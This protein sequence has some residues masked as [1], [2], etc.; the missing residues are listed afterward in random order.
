M[1]I[2]YHSRSGSR[3]LPC[4]A[5]SYVVN[6]D[7]YSGRFSLEVDGQRAEE[8]TRELADR[9]LNVLYDPSNPDS[10][11]IPVK[12]FAGFPLHQRLEEN[13]TKLYPDD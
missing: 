3:T 1:E 5:F 11:F 6:G 4:F 12:Q 10:W 2:V 7:Y 13:L 9:K 8:L